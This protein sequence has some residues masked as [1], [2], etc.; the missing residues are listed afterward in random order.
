LAN[1]RSLQTWHPAMCQYL[2][3]HPRKHGA[4]SS[5]HILEGPPTMKSRAD[6]ILMGEIS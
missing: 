4:D 1:T 2:V 6:E 5:N 3:K